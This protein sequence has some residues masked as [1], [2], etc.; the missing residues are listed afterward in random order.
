MKH[1]PW[2]KCRH[3]HFLFIS[4][5]KAPLTVMSKLVRQCWF[6]SVRCQLC[7]SDSD[8]SASLG[9][10]LL[11]ITEE[12]PIANVMGTPGHSWCDH[13]LLK[14]N[15]SHSNLASNPFYTIQN[16]CTTPGKTNMHIS[17]HKQDVPLISI[18]FIVS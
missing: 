12:L 10:P 8:A 17:Y 5:G 9:M 3:F 18:D 15:I 11:R 14:G 2:V 4:C 16:R 13:K 6:M 7:L 1:T